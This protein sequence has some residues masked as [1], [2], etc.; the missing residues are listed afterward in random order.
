M[1]RLCDVQTGTVREILDYNPSVQF[2]SFP[3]NLVSPDGQFFLEMDDGAHQIKN[4][5]GEVVQIIKVYPQS[6]SRA[7]FSQDSRLLIDGF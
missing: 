1:V 6:D 2:F 4:T 3:T 5:T 7:A